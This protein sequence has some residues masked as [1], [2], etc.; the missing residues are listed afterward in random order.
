[1]YFV[2]SK[3]SGRWSTIDLFDANREKYAERYL[4]Q[5]LDQAG[6]WSV[7]SQP[8]DVQ[9]GYCL[10]F[11]SQ[12]DANYFI[13]ARRAREVLVEPEMAVGFVFEGDAK[14]FCDRGLAEIMGPRE[15]ED[16]FER[17]RQMSE[18]QQAEAHDEAPAEQ[19]APKAKKR[20][21]K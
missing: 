14:Y 4:V 5:V 7:D 6:R 21:K 3:V 12:A 1:M 11:G 8:V 20:G 2:R 10:S 16:M 19:A 13:N 15:V 17:I 9:Q 18:P